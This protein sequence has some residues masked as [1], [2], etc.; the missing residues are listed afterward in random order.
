M[1]SLIFL[2]PIFLL[3]SK[4]QAQ[5]S[6]LSGIHEFYIHASSSYDSALAGIRN[7]AGHPVLNSK[8]GGRTYLNRDVE[9]D[10]FIQSKSN[11]ISS[12]IASF[13]RSGLVGIGTENPVEKLHVTSMTEGDAVL[14]LEADTDNSNES[15]NPR[16]ELLQDGSLHGAFIGFNHDWGETDIQPDNLFRIVTRGG[17]VNDYDNFVIVPGSG[18]VGI[19]TATPKSLLSVNGQIRA[20]EVKVQADINVPDYVFEPGYELRTLKETKEYI[21]KNKH[22]PEIPSSAEIG[23]NGIDLGDMNMRLLKKI[24]ELTL[25]QIELLEEMEAM[26]NRLEQLEN[27]K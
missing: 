4:S 6:L 12:S 17:G 3:L 24:E 11:G 15:D 19:G 21:Q 16:I 23:Q 9:G 14:R 13:L 1:K 7:N 5:E 8:E 2:A 26:E 22:L 10:T 20:K 18:Y 27:K 25:Y